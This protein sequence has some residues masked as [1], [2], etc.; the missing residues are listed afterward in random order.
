MHLPQEEQILR[1][2]FLNK[3]YLHVFNQRGTKPGR[4]SKSCKMNPTGLRQSTVQNR[5]EPKETAGRRHTGKVQQTDIARRTQVRLIRAGTITLEGEKTRKTASVGSDYN[6]QQEM[7]TTTSNLLPEVNT[8]N[9]RRT[10][11]LEKKK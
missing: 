5:K 9:A 4:R 11:H 8:E 2:D 1:N 7:Q 6:M 10:Q 3:S